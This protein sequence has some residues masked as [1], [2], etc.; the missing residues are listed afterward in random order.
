MSANDAPLRLFSLLLSPSFSRCARPFLLRPLL[1]LSLLLL[2]QPLSPAAQ[3]HM[4][5]DVLRDT[6]TV[7]VWTVGDS[8]CDASLVRR[9]KECRRTNLQQLTT[10]KTR[11]IPFLSLPLFSSPEHLDILAIARGDDRQCDKGTRTARVPLLSI[12]CSLGHRSANG[13]RISFT[14]REKRVRHQTQ[15]Q[16]AA[17]A[18]A[19]E[20]FG[21]GNVAQRV[22]QTMRSER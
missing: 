10:G 5:T 12:L 18:A 4:Q 9:R 19:E 20:V 13:L 3:P 21:W 11:A 17:V 14:L 2:S 7:C 22:Q 16:A 1:S 15:N 6:Y 8:S